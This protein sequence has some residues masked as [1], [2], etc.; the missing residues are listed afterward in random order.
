MYI[1]VISGATDHS[2]DK[3]LPW[4]SS[5][6]LTKQDEQILLSGGW[7]SAN[8]ISAVHKLLRK[9]FP[10]QEGLNDTSVLSERLSWP[11]K[12][13]KCVQIIHVSGCHWACLSNRFC[14]D[15][16]IDLYDC[17]HTN[18]TKSEGIMK[19]ACT[20]LQSEESF[21]TVNVINVQYQEGSSDCGLFAAAM[22][23]DLCNEIDPFLNKYDQSKMREHLRQCFEKQQIVS[24]PATVTEASQHKRNRA[25]A[26]VMTEIYCT[27][28]LPEEAPM[29]CCDSCGT[30]YHQGCVNIPDEVFSDDD[31]PW[32]CEICAFLLG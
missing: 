9:A 28:R 21:V 13:N 32:I 23:F 29:A 22:A 3:L 16:E 26:K 1:H 7:L 30:W 17:F 20:I 18:P 31:V 25:V 8:H 4:I 10:T 15:G 19:Q 24:F 2:S 12:P 11:S 5:L 27:C 6:V 14:G